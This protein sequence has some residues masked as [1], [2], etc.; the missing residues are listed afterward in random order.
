[1]RLKRPKTVTTDYTLELALTRLTELSPE[2]ETQIKIL[3]HSILN[4]YPD[5]YEL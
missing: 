1:M 3:N 2:P 4:C 5:L